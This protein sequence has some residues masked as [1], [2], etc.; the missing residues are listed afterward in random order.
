MTVDLPFAHKPHNIAIRTIFFNAIDFDDIP[1]KAI[2]ATDTAVDT[3]I[4]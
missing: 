2:P 4:L 1:K 3:K